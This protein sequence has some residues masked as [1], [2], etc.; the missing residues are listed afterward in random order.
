MPA[1]ASHWLRENNMSPRFES[2]ESRLFLSASSLSAD[3]ATVTSD[4]T[5]LPTFAASDNATIKAD[6]AGQ[7]ITKA[8]K[9]F[10]TKQAKTDDTK[11]KALLKADTLGDSK[12]NRDLGKLQSAVASKQHA[13]AV[14]LN[15]DAAAAL[16]AITRA[17][18]SLD[19]TDRT[20]LAAIATTFPTDTQLQSNIVTIESAGS[21]RIATIQA[22][23]TTAFS[24]DI[25]AIVAQYS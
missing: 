1:F 25:A 3:Q 19:T 12:I 2:L 24:T 20:G 14:K 4:I 8:E 15:A 6:L 18:S 21:A 5:A 16:A 10:A 17:S 13:D 9:A 23:A 22:D 11:Y 7:T